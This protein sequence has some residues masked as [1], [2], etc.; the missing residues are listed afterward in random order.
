MNNFFISQNQSMAFLEITPSLTFVAQGESKILSIYCK[1]FQR[2]A[3]SGLPSGWSA[4]STS[5]KGPTQITIT[6]PNN[7]SLSSIVKQITITSGSKIQ[8]CNLTQAVGYYTYANPVITITY[9]DIPASGG[10]VTPTYSFTQTYGWNGV[11]S[12]VGTIV[13]N[14]NW[15][16]ENATNTTTGAVTAASLGTT[17]KERTVVA[18]VNAKVTSHDKSSTKAIDVW[19]QAN[20]AEYAIPVVSISYAT[21]PASG[22]TVNPTSSFTQKVTYTSTDYETISSGGTWSYSGTNV[23]TTTGAVTAASLGTTEKTTTTKITTATAKVRSH[24][25]EA[26]SSVDVYQ[27]PNNVSSR[28]VVIKWTSNNGASRLLAPSGELDTVKFFVTETFDSGS[29]GSEFNPTSNCSI[30]LSNSTGFTVSGLTVSVPNRGTTETPVYTTNV[31]GIYRG[32]QASSTIS[33]IGGANTKTYGTPTGKVL[34]VEDI[35][36]KG[37]TVSQGAVVG[38]ITQPITWTSGSPDSVTNP[39][40]DES[41]YSDPITAS[42]K[43]TTIS[44]RTVVGTLTYSYKCNGQWGTASATVY[45]QANS[46]KSYS[47]IYMILTYNNNT[48]FAVSG[49]TRSPNLDYEFY[50]YYT[51]DESKTITTGATLTY[52]VTGTGFTINPTTGA[53]TATTNTGSTTRSATATVKAEFSTGDYWYANSAVTQAAMTVS[54]YENVAI[55]I[56]SYN[57]I[58]YTGGSVSYVS[59]V[60][61]DIVYNDGSRVEDN[62]GLPPGYH[63]EFNMVDSNFSINTSTGVVSVGANTS[64]SSR[65]ATAYM[66]VKNGSQLITY[67]STIVRQNGIPSNPTITLTCSYDAQ[68]GSFTVFADAAVRD[69]ISLTMTYYDA[70][71]HGTDVPGYSMNIGDTSISGLMGGP[72]YP[73]GGIFQVNNDDSGSVQAINAIYTWTPP[74]YELVDKYRKYKLI[75]Q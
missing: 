74:Q 73:Y 7:T 11:D 59:D 23:N 24:N 1:R 75:K 71:G 57:D 51:S 43:G 61:Y 8:T 6:A 19:Q 46:I 50:E 58:P 27:N 36:A 54:S 29:T 41:N 5:G 14:G 68:N 31:T 32:T 20:T 17:E 44:D 70:Y 47:L 22:G 9:S 60:T 35:P 42:S 55:N 26:T 33:I 18:E 62:H 15:S 72:T 49:E 40:I 37:G 13:T 2:W 45:Q 34:G 65:S 39:T 25:L 28:V 21:I 10:S 12:G 4:S 69:N 56:Y 30:T 48:P 38:T 16:F 3:L 67:A 64:S 52:S 66:Y 63:T 53:L